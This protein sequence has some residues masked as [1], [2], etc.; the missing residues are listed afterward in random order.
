[1]ACLYY[2][3]LFVQFDKRVTE[4]HFSKTLESLSLNYFQC[5]LSVRPYYQVVITIAR[6][7]LGSGY[8]IDSEEDDEDDILA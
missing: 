3:Y 8:E 7:Y 4:I 6:V 1:M 5:A 2:E